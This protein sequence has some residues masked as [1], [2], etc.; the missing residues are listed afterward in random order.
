MVAQTRATPI[1]FSAGWTRLTLTA[2][3][4]TDTAARLEVEGADHVL[5]YAPGRP[6]GVTAAVLTATLPA[7]RAQSQAFAT[8]AGSARAREVVLAPWPFHS[9]SPRLRR[10]R[11]LAPRP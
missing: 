5:S 6:G 3:A 2:C 11:L 4:R 10:I 1:A 7:A 9:P 8:P